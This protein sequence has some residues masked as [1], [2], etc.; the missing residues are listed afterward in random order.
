MR[1]IYRNQ[2]CLAFIADRISVKYGLLHDEMR[3]GAHLFIVSVG[4]TLGKF[5]HVDPKS[6]S[7]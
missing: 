2:T 1:I 5:T 4:M 3:C 6:G 7:H